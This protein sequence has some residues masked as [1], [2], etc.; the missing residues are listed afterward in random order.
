[1]N[2]PL[3]DDPDAFSL[4]IPS[5]NS[6]RF[7]RRLLSYLRRIEYQGRI[8]LVDSSTGEDRAVVER[9]QVDWPELWLEPFFYPNTLSF[10]A[11]L[12]DALGRISSP[13]VMLCADDDFVVPETLERCVAFLRDHPDHVVARGKSAAFNLNRLQKAGVEGKT[14]ATFTVQPMHAYPQ[15]ETV[16]RLL[17]FMRRYSS[18]FYSVGRR[19][20]MR[21]ALVATCAVT[22]NI[23]FFQYLW[24]C[25]TVAQGMVWTTP[26]LLYIRHM[27]PSSISS[28]MSRESY[29]H[30]PLLITAP[31]FA[32]QYAGFRA[33]LIDWVG[34]HVSGTD[35]E[36]LG[37]MLDHASVDLFRRSFCG[38]E[39]WAPDE[40]RFF[41]ELNRAGSRENAQ[42]RRALDLAHEHTDTY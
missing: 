28:V 23:I 4:I 35:P 38:Q 31:D 17:A 24:S 2:F 6:A 18:T 10:P 1:M 29:E 3:I 33:G 12:I 30:W 37:K 41:S 11:K 7:L 32:A 15:I 9:A 26:E 13:V 16:E 27:R 19:V 36:V 40:K 8:H 39:K 42:L 25:L 22:E 21:D 34:S 5:H 20:A 14:Q